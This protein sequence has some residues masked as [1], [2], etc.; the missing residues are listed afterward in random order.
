MGL[1]ELD[2]LISERKPIISQNQSANQSYW[3]LWETKNELAFTQEVSKNQIFLVCNAN[4]LSRLSTAFDPLKDL[5]AIQNEQ[6]WHSGW[7]SSHCW[8]MFTVCWLVWQCRCYICICTFGD[9]HQS[10]AFFVLANAKNLLDQKYRS[11]EAGQEHIK[12]TPLTQVNWL[13][14]AFA[15]SL[16]SNGHSCKEWNYLHIK[17]S[18]TLPQYNALQKVAMQCMEMPVW[19]ILFSGKLY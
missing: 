19:I 11:H 17:P 14:E 1:L 9:L 10:A 12:K 15:T 7:L 6:H 5:F 16:W 8:W 3:V 13:K 2:S 4:L 18:Q